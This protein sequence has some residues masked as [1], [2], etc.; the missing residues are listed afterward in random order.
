MMTKEEQRT[1]LAVFEELVKM[2][3]SDLNKF[4][5]STTIQEMAELYNKLRYADYCEEHGIEYE[6]MTDEDFEQYY[7]E[8]YGNC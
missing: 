5:G 1:V 4:L 3:Y 6:E 2:P 7:N 8:K